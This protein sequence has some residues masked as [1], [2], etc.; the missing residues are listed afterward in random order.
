MFSD[1]SEYFCW[2]QRTKSKPH[3]T[4]PAAVTTNENIIISSFKSSWELFSKCHILYIWYQP[5]IQNQYFTLL[6]LINIYQLTMKFDRPRAGHAADDISSGT[7]VRLPSAGN[8]T[9]WRHVR[10]KCTCT[11][12]VLY[13]VINTKKT[14]KCSRYF[15]ED[16]KSENYETFNNVVL[17]CG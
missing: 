11:R 2:S 15:K 13:T 9:L 5:Q 17:V 8:I 12:V 7:T 6:Y 1:F 10:M 14:V 16:R 3:G 4:T